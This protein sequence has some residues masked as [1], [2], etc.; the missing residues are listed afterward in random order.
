M[1]QE[2]WRSIHEIKEE[3]EEFLD[4]LAEELDNDNEIK[5]EKMENT[6]KELEEVIRLKEEE[7]EN[8]EEINIPNYYRLFVADSV[9]NIL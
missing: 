1:Q 2:T 6:I 9:Q 5:M 3:V 7:N 8:I 4:I